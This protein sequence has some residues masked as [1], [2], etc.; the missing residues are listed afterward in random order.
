MAK[1]FITIELTESELSEIVAQKYNLKNPKVNITKV[2]EGL[3]DYWYFKITVTS[4]IKQ[5]DL[6]R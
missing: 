2:D 3:E 5:E 1:Q 4:E 6:M